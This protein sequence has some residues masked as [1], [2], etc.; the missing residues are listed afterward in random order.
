[1]IQ[2]LPA[3]GQRLLQEAEGYDAVIVAGRVVLREDQLTGE[4]PG[5]LVRAGQI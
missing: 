3:G 5:R 1:M 2:D 4:L